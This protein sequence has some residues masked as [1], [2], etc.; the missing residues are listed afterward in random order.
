MGQDVAHAIGNV[1]LHLNKWEVDFA[2]WCNYKYIN[3]GPSDVGGF[4][5]TIYM[6]VFKWLSLQKFLKLWGIFEKG[7][8]IFE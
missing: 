5:I 1:E 3:G 8:K 2:A 6:V 7:F 4:L